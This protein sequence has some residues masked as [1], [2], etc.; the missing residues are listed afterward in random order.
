VPEIP[1]K[2]YLDARDDQLMAEVR[3]A[4]AELAEEGGEELLVPGGAFAALRRAQFPAEASLGRV[5]LAVAKCLASIQGAAETK[6]RQFS[7]LELMAI[8]GLAAEQLE[9]EARDA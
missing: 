3:D 1:S 4:R 2:T 5:V 9:R 6:G 8:G 7:R